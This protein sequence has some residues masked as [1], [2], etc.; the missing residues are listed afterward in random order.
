VLVQR[1]LLKKTSRKNRNSILAQPDGKES[2]PIALKR[3]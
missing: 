1:S 3:H 2:P